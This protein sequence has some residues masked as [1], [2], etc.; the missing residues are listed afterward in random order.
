M[1]IKDYEISSK[2]LEKGRKLGRGNFADVFRLDIFVLYP[3][4]MSISLSKS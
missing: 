1:K 3:I 2:D 4:A